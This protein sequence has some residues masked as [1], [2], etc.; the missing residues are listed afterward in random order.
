M[1]VSEAILEE[2]ERLDPREWSGEVFRWVLGDRDALVANVR[3]ARWNPPQ[4]SALYTAL[5]RATVVAECEYLIGS[6]PARP[7]VPPRLHMLRVRLGKLLDLR[8]GGVLRRLGVQED[9]AD[10]PWQVC[11]EI[12]AAAHLLELDGL[13]VPSARRP[14]G[15]SLVIF[16]AN[17]VKLD[18]ELELVSSE[19][20]QL[21]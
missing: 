19:V 3:G 8:E 21:G 2:L 9:L 18:A 1:V 14:E 17:H 11:Q 6:S 15:S 5:E 16:P 20:L 7:R 12:G 13:L 10:V 4:V